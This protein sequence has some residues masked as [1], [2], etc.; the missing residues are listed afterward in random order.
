LLFI[1]YGYFFSTI[2]Y[3]ILIKF[4]WYIKHEK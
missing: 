3:F 2:K 4:S 1:F